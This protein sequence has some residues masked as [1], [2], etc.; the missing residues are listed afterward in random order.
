[1][2]RRRLGDADT[3]TPLSWFD[4]FSWIDHC[5]TSGASSSWEPLPGG[6]TY[7]NLRYGTLSPEQVSAL[8]GQAVANNNQV[9]A[10]AV[11]AYGSDSSAVQAIDQVLAKQN[12][13]TVADIWA[14]NPAPGFGTGVPWY[15]WALGAVALLLA[16]RR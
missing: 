8:A 5:D 11:A 15:V 2:R 14:L 9:R 12:A 6:I 10:N 13:A 7:P 3:C 4:P 16:V 1:M